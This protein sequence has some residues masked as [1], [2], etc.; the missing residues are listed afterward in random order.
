MLKKQ[1]SSDKRNFK[2]LKKLIDSQRKSGAGL[3]KDRS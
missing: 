1:Q 3:R 2:S